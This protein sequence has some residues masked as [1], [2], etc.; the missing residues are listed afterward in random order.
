M[1]PETER[2]SWIDRYQKFLVAAGGAI[3]EGAALWE[4][5]PAVAG[6]VAFITAALV[7]AI[8]NAPEG[9]SE[10]AT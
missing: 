10:P 7:A 3:I 6:T 8:G 9:N 5:S 1:V 4:G 2:P